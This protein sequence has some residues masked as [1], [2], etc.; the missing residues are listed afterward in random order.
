[1]YP[2][3]LKLEGQ[4]C[5]V[6]G[7]GTIAERKIASLLEHGGR[8]LV[9]TPEASDKIHRWAENGEVRLLQRTYREGDAV[10]HFLV[11]AATNV[12][13]VNASVARDCQQRNIL[14]NAVD[15]QELSNFFVPASVR[16]GD[17]TIAISTGGA[18]PA[19]AKR[20]RREIEG[21]FGEEYA[22]FLKIMAELREQVLRDVP[23]P[24]R[25]KAIFDRLADAGL[26]ALLKAGDH[27]TVKER[28][29]QCLSLS[30]D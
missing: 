6:V 27:Q 1:M 12:P 21:V 4:P 26:L 13:D 18:S 10:G 20:I 22:D 11:V 15:N 19:V 23:D 5:L 29:A 3:M 14:I 16:R 17:L 30:S 7:G 25:R 24:A 28:I 2:L 9:I 8:V